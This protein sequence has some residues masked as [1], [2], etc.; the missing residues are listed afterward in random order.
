M[1]KKRDVDKERHSRKQRPEVS[2][3]SG[4]E[5]ARVIALHAATVV[6]IVAHKLFNDPQ[7]LLTSC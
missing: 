5:E 4:A 3:G 7:R 2:A 1:I 6:L